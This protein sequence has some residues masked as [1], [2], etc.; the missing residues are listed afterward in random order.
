MKLKHAVGDTI[1]TLRHERN[2]TLRNLSSK[3]HVALGHISD[4]ERGRKG[5]S[6]ELLEAIAGGLDLS[7]AD[8]IWEIYEYLREHNA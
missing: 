2:M 4:V 3:S 8:L 5:A 7:T 1:R 6:N